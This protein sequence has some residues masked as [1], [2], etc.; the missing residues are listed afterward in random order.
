M[1]VILC[2]A[3]CCNNFLMQRMQFTQSDEC[4]GINRSWVLLDTSSTDST[5]NDTKHVTNVV[6]CKIADEMTALTNRGP[7]VFQKEAGFGLFP[8]KVYFDQHSLATVISYHQVKNLP[9]FKIKV[10][11]EI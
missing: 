2:S 6:Q 1:Q 11:T 3:I 4:E 9:G 8:M 5:C 7:R 10:D